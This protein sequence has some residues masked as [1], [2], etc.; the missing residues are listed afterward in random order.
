MAD[1]SSR[2]HHA[3][4]G[5]TSQSQRVVAAV[6]AWLRPAKARPTGDEY[7]PLYEPP[8]ALADE[9]DDYE[10]GFNALPEDE[11]PFSW[12]EYSLFAVIGMAMMWPWCVSPTRH[13]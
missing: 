13:I 5:T 6:N 9:D 7:E 4:I 1:P 10:V 3:E 12:F 8:T 2:L 11:V